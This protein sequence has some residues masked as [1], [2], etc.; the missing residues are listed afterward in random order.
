MDIGAVIILIL[1]FFC[2]GGVGYVLY[3]DSAKPKRKPSKKNNTTA[4]NSKVHKAKNNEIDHKK[5]KNNKEVQILDSQDILEFEEIIVCNEETAL[6]KYDENT[7]LGYIDVKGINFNLMS[8]DERIMLEE[9]FGE[10]L[11]GI[12]FSVQFYTQSRRIDLDDYINNYQDRIEQ[13]K[14]Q[15]KAMEERGS[16]QEEIDRITNQIEYGEKLLTYYTQRT[17]NSD[18]KERR[19]YIV[20]KYVHSADSF[21]HKL[22]DYEILTSAYSDIQNKAALIIDSLLRNNLRSKLLS[23]TEI[24]EML[25]TAYNRCDSSKLKFKNAVESGFNHL[26]STSKPVE[27]KKLE[28]EIIKSEEREMELMNEIEQMRKELGA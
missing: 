23:A 17:I 4:K 1:C 28:L 6:L 10:L 16:S 24:G 22:D 9:S 14:L 15:K 12:D 7:F 20:I 26:F 21:E 5:V 19:Y 2:I 3:K 27:L 8:I 13:I 11:N 18:L 25:Y